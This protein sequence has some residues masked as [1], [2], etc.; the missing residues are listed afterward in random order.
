MDSTDI[1]DLGA[2]VAGPVLLPDDVRFPAEC[3]TFNLLNP[4]RPAVAVGALTVDDVQAAVRFAAERE[5]PVAVLATGHQ[6]ARTA[7][8]SVLINL[9]RMSAR[10]LD[11]KRGL[12]HLEHQAAIV[13]IGPNLCWF[14]TKA[15]TV[16]LDE[17]GIVA[18][19][20]CDPQ[21]YHG[22]AVLERCHAKPPFIVR[23]VRISE[24]EEVS[25]GR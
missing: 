23:L 1:A 2:R 15:S 16:K 21:L 13:V 10:Y 14:Q 22:S 5:L 17:A 4:V 3:A 8:G 7:E 18:G 6:M 24:L 25:D 20:E 11:L 9:S 19:G 12:A